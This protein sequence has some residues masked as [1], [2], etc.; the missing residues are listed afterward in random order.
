MRSTA[1]IWL[2]PHKQEQEAFREHSSPPM[3]EEYAEF[4]LEWHNLAKAAQKYSWI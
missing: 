4:N 1:G 2:L 3:P